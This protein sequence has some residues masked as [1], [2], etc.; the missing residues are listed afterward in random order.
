[1]FCLYV[2]TMDEL[3]DENILSVIR[4]ISIHFVNIYSLNLYLRH[5]KIHLVR[6]LSIVTLPAGS[7]N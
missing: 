5:C 2:K 4:S 6:P 1:M 7:V 3:N